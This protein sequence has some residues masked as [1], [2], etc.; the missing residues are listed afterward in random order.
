VDRLRFIP[1]GMPYEFRN[2]K[3]VADKWYPVT[4][5]G[6]RTSNHQ[7][8]QYGQADKPSPCFYLYR[9]MV[10]NPDGG[11]SPCCVV[12]RKDRDFAQLDPDTPIDVGALWNNSKYQSARSLF[13]ARTVAG[14]KPTVC[15]GCDIFARHPSKAGPSR[16]PRVLAQPVRVHTTKQPKASDAGA[17]TPSGPQ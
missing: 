6:R 15:D 17:S 7:E 1:V 16:P 14:R 11:V 5:A 12:Y 2:R 8:Q 10:V 4:V 9:S 13:S 3:E